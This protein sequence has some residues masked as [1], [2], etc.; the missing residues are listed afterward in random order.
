M[1]THQQI[2]ERERWLTIRD[3]AKRLDM[4]ESSVRREIRAGR[5]RAYRFGKIIKVLEADFLMYRKS[6]LISEPEVN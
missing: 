4:G 3:I 5:L 2:I 6:C 1:N